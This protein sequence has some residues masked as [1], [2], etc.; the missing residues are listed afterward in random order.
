MSSFLGEELSRGPSDEKVPMCA[1]LAMCIVT[2]LNWGVKNGGGI[3]D[4]LRAPAPNEPT[5]F[6]RYSWMWIG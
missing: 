5:F 2:T 3:G 1:T 4:F 6:L